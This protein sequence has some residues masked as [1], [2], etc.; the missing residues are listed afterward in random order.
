MVGK[1][2]LLLLS[3]AIESSWGA[4][5]TFFSVPRRA[6]VS[7]LP[8]LDV[9]PGVGVGVGWVVRARGMPD[10]MLVFSELSRWPPGRLRVVLS[11]R[12]AAGVET[13]SLSDFLSREEPPPKL[14]S[15]GTDNCVAFSRAFT[16]A[17]LKL[18]E[19][20][21]RFPGSFRA[22]AEWNDTTTHQ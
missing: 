9:F 22:A 7:K 8:V 15:S 5:W 11:A 6:G 21:D 19:L 14:L 10:V 3:S 13:S 1:G 20:E 18:K 2:I 12:A 17:A 16:T 4:M